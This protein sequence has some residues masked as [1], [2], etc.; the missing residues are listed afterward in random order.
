MSMFNAD[1]TRLS[2]DELAAI[3]VPE[4]ERK[5][6]KTQPAGERVFSAGGAKADAIVRY[7]L[8]GGFSREQ[9]A[10]FVGASPSR[11]GEV[12]WCLDAAGVEHPPLARKT[13]SKAADEPAAE[14]V[15]DA[16]AP[17]SPAR[18]NSKARKVS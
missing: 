1:I 10:Y 17:V 2:D 13:A 11:V 14:V 4:F 18:K 5:F 6:T 8:H 15:A 9:I 3:S 12:V 16:P 7:V